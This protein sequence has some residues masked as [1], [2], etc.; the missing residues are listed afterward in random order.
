ML[1]DLCV[2]PFQSRVNGHHLYPDDTEVRV[3][4]AILDYASNRVLTWQ[5]QCTDHRLLKALQE[6]LARYGCWLDN[7]LVERLW[8]SIKYDEVNTGRRHL[9]NELC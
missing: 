7:V 3:F 5:L 6:P 1:C 2:Y 4:I 9:R 8:K